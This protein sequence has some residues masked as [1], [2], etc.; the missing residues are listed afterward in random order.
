[1]AMTEIR[2]T[3]WATF[4]GGLLLGTAVATGGA[5][6]ALKYGPSLRNALMAPD[7]GEEEQPDGPKA[8]HRRRH[9]R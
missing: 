5:F 3:R 9:A 6:L 7:S 2:D 1:M 4:A 8:G